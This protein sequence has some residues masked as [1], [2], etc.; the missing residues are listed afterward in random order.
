MY[1]YDNYKMLVS[2][3]WVCIKNHK[4]I[5]CRH[6]KLSSKKLKIHLF[7]VKNESILIQTPRGK[8][9]LFDCGSRTA[10]YDVHRKI[11]DL[12]IKKIHVMVA[13]HPHEDHSAGFATLSEI[14]ECNVKL[15]RLY[16]NGESGITDKWFKKY[17]KFRKNLPNNGKYYPLKNTKVR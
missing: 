1:K 8:N 3:K 17:D 16:D 11:K 5:G 15:G 4:K 10:G 6:K 9:I 13:S 12:K 14:K 7:H 2:T